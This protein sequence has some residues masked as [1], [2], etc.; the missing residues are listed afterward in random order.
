MTAFD[1]LYIAIHRQSVDTSARFVRLILSLH[2][3]HK[4]RVSLGLREIASMTG[5]SAEG[6][7]QCIARLIDAGEVSVREKGA[8][9][10]PSVYQI[11]RMTYE[12][13]PQVLSTEV[14]LTC[15]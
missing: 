10:R 5:L 9:S 4:G 2:S 12:E 13:R 15:H 11:E 1:T 6:V 14:T 3:D 8:G 7:S